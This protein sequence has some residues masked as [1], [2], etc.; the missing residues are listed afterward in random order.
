LKI[1]RVKI[2]RAKTSFYLIFQ[3][4]QNNTSAVAQHIASVA[5]ICTLE[6][7]LI[8]LFCLANEVIRLGVVTNSRLLRRCA[9]RQPKYCFVFLNE[10]EN[11]IFSRY[12]QS[13]IRINTI[14]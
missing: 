7:N 1:N 5:R 12:P 4:K 14:F 8:T 13:V 11:K 10:V 3:T 2:G 6:T 9:E